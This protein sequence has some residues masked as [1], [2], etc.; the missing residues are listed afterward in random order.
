LAIPVE[1]GE[2]WVEVFLD[3]RPYF[4]GLLGPPLFFLSLA[5]WRR[6]VRRAATDGPG[7]SSLAKELAP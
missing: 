6:Q 4:L 5:L 3:P 7:R 1:A 2:H